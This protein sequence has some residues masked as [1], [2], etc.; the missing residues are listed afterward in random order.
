MI[1]PYDTG[2][3]TKAELEALKAAHETP[4]P[5]IELIP[6]WAVVGEVH[7]AVRQWRNNRIAHLTERL[8]VAKERFEHNID[9]SFDITD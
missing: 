9:H 1:Y 6:D 7:N 4:E 5:T 2:I 8:D 3:A